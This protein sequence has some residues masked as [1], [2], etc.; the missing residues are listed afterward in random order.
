MVHD[1]Y[2]EKE[3]TLISVLFIVCLMA[4][5]VIAAAALVTRTTQTA[6]WSAERT[7]ALYAAE[8][9]LN[10]WLYQMSVE[11]ADDPDGRDSSFEDMILVLA[12]QGE[13]NKIPY[14]AKIDEGDSEEGTY[15]LVSEANAGRHPIKVSLLLG[16]V[17]E[18]WKHVVYSTEQHHEVTE[19]LAD[20]GYAVNEDSQWTVDGDDSPPIWMKNGKLVPLPI[21][22]E[23]GEGYR[24][25]L[26]STDLAEWN[27]PEE[28][29]VELNRAGNTVELPTNGPVYY[30][31][32]KIGVNRRFG[33][34]SVS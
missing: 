9:G 4:M 29:A 2:S 22:E 13:A 12:V 11:A 6:A 34:R 30:K 16:Q 28:N 24:T 10:H 25:G 5:A 23:G 15:R 3:I 19:A 18:A 17:S 8:A 33:R 20:K 27:P 14:V 32:S 26:I 21:W 7:K 1:E 31:N